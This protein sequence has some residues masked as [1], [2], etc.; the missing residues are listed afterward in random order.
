[1]KTLDPN[2]FGKKIFV[3]DC[4]KIKIDDILRVSE[5]KL[6]KLLLELEIKSQG[7]IIGVNTSDTRFGGKRNWFACPICQKR[8]GVLLE[9]PVTNK[10]GC[11]TCLEL[12]YRK[13]KNTG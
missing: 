1:M 8:V 11:R 4:R 9:H 13:S 3:E 10:L 7:I 2:D 6:K 12:V 5:T